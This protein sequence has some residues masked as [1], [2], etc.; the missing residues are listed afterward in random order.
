MLRP[1]LEGVSL[2]ALLFSWAWPAGA[3]APLAEAP[4]V[5]VV[6]PAHRRHRI[7]P[8]P[9]L[10]VEPGAGFTTGLRGRYVY[11]EPD[12][13]QNRVTLDLVSRISVR[14]V[15][16]HEMRLRMRDLAGHNEIFDVNFRF[17]SDP[18][19]T[20]TGIANHERLTN[21]EINDERYEAHRLSVG[22]DVNV[23]LPV[24]R[25]EPE[26]WFGTTQA[27]LRAFVGWNFAV[28]RF[29]AEPDSL[30]AL[31][32]PQA[33][34]TRRRGTYYGGL[35]WDSRNNDWNPK[36]GGFYDISLATGGPWAG[37]QDV[38]SRFNASFRNYQSLGTDRLVLAHEL[39][40]ELQGGDVPLIAKGEFSGLVFRDGVGGLDTGRGFFRRRFVGKRKL[41][42]S[43]E[44]RIEPF[45]IWLGP[46]SVEPGIKPFVDV[47]W[48]QEEGNAAFDEGLHLSG[49]A[50]LYLVWDEFE[51]I[52]VDFGVS[53]EGMGFVMAADHAF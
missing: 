49:G 36:R 27:F 43:A 40:A 52:R 32:E 42:T 6:E 51:V 8:V 33:P 19:F 10:K 24:V 41:F 11:R 46:F 35:T 9:V 50:G 16:Q 44:L 34:G 29:R 23:Q 7:L 5:D 48:V 31:D 45:Q 14:L 30:F 1:D 26:A 38:W 15:Q 20:Y 18:V 47:A 22:P 17:E 53:P 28:D 21:A 25:L 4:P 13:V 39:L 2:F 37:G 12:D 3:E